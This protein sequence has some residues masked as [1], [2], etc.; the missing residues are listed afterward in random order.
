MWCWGGSIKTILNSYGIPINQDQIVARVYGVPV[1]E[2]GTDDAISASLNGWGFDSGGRRVVVR[3]RVVPG[4]PPLALLIGQFAQQ[5]P[6]LVTFD[7]G[8][9]SG[10]AGV[11]TGISHI[12]RGI[13]SLVYRDPWPTPENCATR[14]RVEL[15]GAGITP[16]LSRVRSHWLV[17]V[18]IS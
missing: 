4:P 16:F 3:S 15:F 5:C 8:S 2:S 12:G 6:I 18:S 10:H 17:S 13:T 11:I 14:G 7:Q 1:N 9:P